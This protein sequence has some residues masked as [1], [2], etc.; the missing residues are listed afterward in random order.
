MAVLMM[1]KGCKPAPSLSLSPTSVDMTADGGKVEIAVSANYNWTAESDE[2]WIRFGNKTGT[3]YDKTLQ[4][5][6]MAND[7]PDDREAIV[8]VTCEDVVQTIKIHQ[9]QQDMVVPV[10]GREVTLSCEAQQVE[11]EIQANVA[12]AVQLSTSASWIK[13]IGTRALKESS[14]IIAVEAN[15]SHSSRE[16]RIDFT[17]GGKALKD[18]TITQSGQ[19]QRLSMIHTL[20]S[21]DA[22]KM[23][24]FGMKGTVFWGDGSQEEYDI[25]LHH[26]YETD[27]PHEVVIEITEVIDV[28]V[29]DVVGIEK[30]DL[31]EF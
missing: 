13:V 30:V 11:L 31:S 14:V 1:A 2:N 4:I 22:P 29:P 28:S 19:P 23:F 15:E 5:T 12:Y 20:S 21:F 7:T 25:P 6:V 24:G 3:E 16:A 10:D 27:G 17:V 9:S 18:L 8:T 26:D